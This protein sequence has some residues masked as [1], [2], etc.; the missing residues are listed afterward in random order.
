M[1]E[2]IAVSMLT[3]I[4]ALSLLALIFRGPKPETPK[5]APANRDASGWVSIPDSLIVVDSTGF[6]NLTNDTVWISIRF[7][8]RPH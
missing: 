7:V 4:L 1:K 2:I 3:T 8:V 6:H 5:P